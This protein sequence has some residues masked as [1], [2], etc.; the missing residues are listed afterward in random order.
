M[1]QYP[2]SQLFADTVYEDIAF[3]PTNIKMLN[4]PEVVKEAMEF[5]GLAE[6]FKDKSPF[7]IS[8]RGT[9]KSGNCRNYC[10]E[11]RHFNFR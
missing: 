6:S 5:V 11:T 8:R 2:E 1:F 9:K 3:G 7:E 10:N 4:I